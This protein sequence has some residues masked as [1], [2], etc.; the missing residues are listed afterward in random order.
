MGAE[1]CALDRASSATGH[2]GSHSAQV[3]ST[4]PYAG[5]SA[6]SQAVIAPAGTSTL[7]FWYRVTCPDSVAYD[8]ATATLRDNTTSVT[9]TVLSH[10]C[11]NT[12]AWVQVTAHV[13]AGHS[14][15][16]TLTSHDDDW[17][18]D[19]TYTLYDDVSIS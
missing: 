12:G 4:S 18:G 1:D 7:T 6:I 13:T 9:A 19:T 10:T 16:L 15:T 8:W 2:T 14:Y 5:D 3:G 17:V 11:T